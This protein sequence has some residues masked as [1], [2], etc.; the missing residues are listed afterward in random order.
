MGK[1]DT[2]GHLNR[3]NIPIPS[4]KHTKPVLLVRHPTSR[5]TTD[6]RKALAKA[7]D[8]SGMLRKSAQ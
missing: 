3:A 4:G 6:F 7:G 2:A 8:D 1:D 5:K